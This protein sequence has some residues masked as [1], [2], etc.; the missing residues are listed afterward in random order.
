MHRTMN[1]KFS[2]EFFYSMSSSE[3]E[4]QENQ[5]SE[6]RTVPDGFLCL[7]FT[8]HDRFG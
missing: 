3:H 2:V 6:S 5:Y 8:F 1:I 7:I 4:F